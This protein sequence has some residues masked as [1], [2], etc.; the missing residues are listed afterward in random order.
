MFQKG[1]SCPISSKVELKIFHEREFSG[2]G[3]EKQRTLR[4]SKERRESSKEFDKL[5]FIYPVMGP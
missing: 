3:N 4:K 1:N 2:T 5:G